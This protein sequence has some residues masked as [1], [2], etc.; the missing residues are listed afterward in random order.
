MS[1]I[2]QIPINNLSPDPCQPRQR[3]N[4]K[5]LREMAVSIK[6]EGII[7]P[8]E[9]DSNNVIVTGERRWRA[10][11]IAGLESVPCFVNDIQ[12]KERYK[13]QLIENA[14]HNTMSPID[15]AKAYINL[16][17]MY[18]VK[19]GRKF[20]NDKG[21]SWLSSELGTSRAMIGKHLQLLEETEGFQ[22]AV[23]DGK[24][25][26]TTVEVL[27]TCPD[28]Y[29]RK[30]RNRLI[31]GKIGSR[32]SGCAIVR[33]IRDNPDKADRIA[34]ED[35]TGKSYVDVIKMLDSIVPDK[36]EEALNHQL[37]SGAD[38]AKQ[39]SQLINLLSVTPLNQVSGPNLALVLM[40]LSRLKSKIDQYLRGQ[41]IPQIIDANN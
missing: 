41:E 3:F 10:A 12:G 35:Y 9:I 23:E 33:A 40:G 24:I 22:N 29:K 38:I 27:R 16:M 31:E 1:E 20:Y 14:H 37:E 11:K 30:I 2:L 39:A 7:N 4:D 19:G 13:H 8:I 32:D 5:E 21:I 34:N 25:G 28:K 6:N 18:K 26:V 36:D 15:T 17:K